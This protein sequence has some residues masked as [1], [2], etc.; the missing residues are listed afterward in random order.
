[1]YPPTRADP[2]TAPTDTDT[3]VPTGMARRADSQVRRREEVLAAV[4]LELRRREEGT[5]LRDWSYDA[6]APT[7]RV[8]PAEILFLPRAERVMGVGTGTRERD[9]GRGRDDAGVACWAADEER[10]WRGDGWGY[11]GCGAVGNEPLIGRPWKRGGVRRCT[12]V[13]SFTDIMLVG[14]L[15][16]LTCCLFCFHVAS[17]RID[18]CG[19]KRRTADLCRPRLQKVKRVK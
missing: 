14:I 2:D 13:C 15:G 11:G 8:E 7:L 18:S 19:P 3:D 12:F 4:A 1:M 9:E 5:G 17:I 16:V 6:E 10:G